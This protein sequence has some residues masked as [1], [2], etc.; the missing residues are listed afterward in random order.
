MI[1]KGTYS[2]SLLCL[3]A[4]LFTATAKAQQQK[5]G[6]VDTDYI[7][8]QMPEYEGVQ[9]QLESISSEWNA[10]LE[11]MK[12]EIANLKE[13]FQAKEILYSDELREK[14]QQ[15][16]QTKI[17]QRQKFLDQKFG[18]EGEYFDKQ[19]ELL[20][21]I[22]RKVFNAVNVVARRGD[23]DFVFDRAQNS[24]MLYSVQ[25]WNLNDEVLEELDV[26]LNDTSN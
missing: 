6:Y 22:Q 11:K 12:S 25:E 17:N 10:E 23:F 8:S 3:V 5:I 26:T 15:E 1:R 20:E 9:Q 19:Q 4:V 13:D 24:N 14:R 18:T 2:F 21:P 7:L 16:I